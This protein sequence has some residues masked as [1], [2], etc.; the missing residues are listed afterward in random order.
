MTILKTVNAVSGMLTYTQNLVE[1]L[2]K[3]IDLDQISQ[4]EIGESLAVIADHLYMNACSL[5]TA[6]DDLESV[7][8]SLKS[9]QANPQ[10]SRRVKASIRKIGTV[11]E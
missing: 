6:V 1:D 2:M 3:Q 8:A 7:S 4:E 11:R 5:E 10:S 9:I